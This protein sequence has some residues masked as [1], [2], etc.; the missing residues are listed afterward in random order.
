[1]LGHVYHVLMCIIVVPQGGLA[2]LHLGAKM[3]HTEVIRCLLLSG[4]DPELENK[5]NNEKC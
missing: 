3:G 5:V 4:A 1:M 2:P